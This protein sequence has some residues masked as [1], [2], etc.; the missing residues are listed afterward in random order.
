MRLIE[1]EEVYYLTFPAFGRVFLS[2]LELQIEC[3]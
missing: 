2:L 1:L 3:H